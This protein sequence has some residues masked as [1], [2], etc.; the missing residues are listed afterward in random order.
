MDYI[1]FARADVNMRPNPEEVQDVKFVNEEQLK[2]LMHPDSQLLW[3]P[4]F[5]IIV[6]NFLGAWW[7]DLDR[8]LSSDDLCDWKKVHK[9][10]D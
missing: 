5:R 10:T 1:L 3:S 4:W 9:L 2:E 8:T 6:N 7:K